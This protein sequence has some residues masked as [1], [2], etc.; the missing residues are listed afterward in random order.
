MRTSFDFANTYSKSKLELFRTCK[1]A[2]H[3]SYLDEVISPNK[4]NYKKAWDFKTVGQAVHSAITLFYHLNPEKRTLETLKKL[5]L[6]C[7]KSEIMKRKNPPLGK[8]GG[9]ESLDHERAKYAEALKLLEIFYNFGDI[10]PN[11]FYL[12]TGDLENSINDYYDLA[13]PL[14]KTPF[15]LS[16]KIDRIDKL[17]NNNLK[18]I[19]FK[20]GRE[21]D[22]YF[23]LRI[24]KFLAERRFKKTVEK[25]SFYYLKNQITQDFDLTQEDLGNIEEEILSKIDEI[26]TEKRFEPKVSKLC[27]FC[28][29]F[30]ICPANDDAQKVIKKEP[31]EETSDDLP[32]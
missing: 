6:P 24:Y 5:L 3:F 30:E 31:E 2:Y 21:S 9:F 7:W 14:A 8:Y 19:D 4:R 15:Q 29:F 27:K 11:L 25:A 23:Q 13:T 20:T 22:S 16:G 17:E 12:P 10:T 18:V 28:D 26:L 32:F 1:K